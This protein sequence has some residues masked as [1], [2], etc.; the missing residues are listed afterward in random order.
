MLR[1][2]DESL[3]ELA[4]SAH[5]GAVQRMAINVAVGAVFAAFLPWRVCAI[6]TSLSIA[7]ELQAWFATR[8]Q[9]LGLPV[10][11]KSASG[12]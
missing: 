12:I 2:L 3:D 10:G 5:A 6:W 11:W 1:L 8:R 4:A 7:T 9:F